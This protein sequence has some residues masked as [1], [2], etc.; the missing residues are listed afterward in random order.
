MQFPPISRHFIPPWSKYSFQHPVFKHPQSVWWYILQ[1]QIIEFVNLYMDPCITILS[2]NIIDSLKSVCVVSVLFRCI[3]MYL[4]L[5]L[6]F[7]LEYDII[8][9]RMQLHLSM[10]SLT[11]CVG[12]KRPASGVSVMPKLFHCPLIHIASNCNI[13][14]FK[15]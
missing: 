5:Y 15:I 13:S 4:L 8:P 10:L 6:S 14:W 12:H 9:S 2:I 3:I 1:T 11:T 7:L